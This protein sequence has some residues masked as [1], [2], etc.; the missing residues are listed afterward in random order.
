MLAK[1]AS[2]GRVLEAER[3]PH[4]HTHIGL[5]NFNHSKSLSNQATGSC[6][7]YV[8]MF[9]GHLEY[10]GGCAAL[11]RTIWSPSPGILYSVQHDL[12]LPLES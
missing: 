5:F 8:Q 3:P 7:G 1:L 6:G 4:T 9:K 2:V 12:P 10:E 11:V